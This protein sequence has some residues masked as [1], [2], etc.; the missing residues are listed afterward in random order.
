MKATNILIELRAMKDTD[1]DAYSY[2]AEN[3]G[4]I[5]QTEEYSV[6]DFYRTACIFSFADTSKLKVQEF[7][8]KGISTG[9]SYRVI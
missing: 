3:G 2:V 6:D 9:Y 5:E 1:V 8:K 7:F 4:I